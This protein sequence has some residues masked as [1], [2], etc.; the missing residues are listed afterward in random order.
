[1]SCSLASRK[2]KG[3]V[4]AWRVEWK[5]LNLSLDSALPPSKG[6]Y[7]R[8]VLYCSTI[9]NFFFSA[10]DSFLQCVNTEGLWKLNHLGHWSLGVQQRLWSAL[11]YLTVCFWNMSTIMEQPFYDD[12]FLSAYGHPGAALPDYKLLKQ[13]MNLNFS[14]SYRN[15]NFKAQHGDFYSAGD[16]GSLKLAS[17]ELERLIDH[18]EQQRGHHYDADA[19]AIP[20]PRHHRGAGGL[21]WRLCEGTGR[22]AQDEPDGTSKCVYRLRRVLSLNAARAARIHHFEQL[23]QPHV[24]CAQLPVHHHQLPA[25]SPVPTAPSGRGARLASLPAT[26]PLSLSALLWLKRGAPDRARHAQQWQ[27]LSANVPY[28]F[29]KP[30]THQSRAQAS[31]E[32]SG[33]IQVSAAQTGAHRPSGGKG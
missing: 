21:R 18:P 12:S 27:Q 8:L 28:R 7:R 13:N 22:P 14:E 26:P 5:H 33:S 2:L 3:E 25:A 29:G 24:F 6:I 11:L 15:S 23:H 30:G 4:S 19:R 32:P 1:M 17:P 31:Q 16:V 10:F 9:W 20:L